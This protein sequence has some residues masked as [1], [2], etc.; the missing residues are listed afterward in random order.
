MNPSDAINENFAASGQPTRRIGILIDGTN[1]HR[2]R[3]AL[4]FDIDYRKPLDYFH[5]Q[6]Q[7]IRAYFYS[8]TLNSPKYTSLN[9]AP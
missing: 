6:G 4:G 7:L 2:T 5:S 3:T 9:C 8:V 1:L